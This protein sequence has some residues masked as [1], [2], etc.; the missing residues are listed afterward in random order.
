[1]LRDSFFGRIMGIGSTS[2]VRVVVG[3]WDQSPFGRFADA[4]IADTFGRRVLL[5][6]TKTVADYVSS[7][8]TFDEIVVEDIEVDPFFSVR[9]HSLCLDVALGERGLLGSF[10]R[11]IP[12]SIAHSPLLAELVDPIAS[13]MLPGVR[14]AGSAGSGRREY[15]C[16]T[17]HVPVRAMAGTWRGMPL[18]EL[19]PVTPPP[20]FGFASS[21]AKPS[22]VSLRTVVD[23]PEP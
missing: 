6:P 16:A 7:T 12:R 14:T 9:S 1:M 19:A 15:Y 5:A 17:D 23:R 4:M 2:G 10:L 18:G 20:A 22:V 11:A 21:P 8:Y 3:S 13:A